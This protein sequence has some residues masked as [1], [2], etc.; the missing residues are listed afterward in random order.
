MCFPPLAS[1]STWTNQDCPVN[2]AEGP[3]P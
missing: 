1:G 2:N 3:I